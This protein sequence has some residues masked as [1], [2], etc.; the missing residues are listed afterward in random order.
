MIADSTKATPHKSSVLKLLLFFLKTNRLAL[1]A[2]KNPAA[3]SAVTHKSSNNDD[4]RDSKSTKSD[5]GEHHA[6][7]APGAD[8]PNT[9]GIVY[10]ADFFIIYLLFRCISR[11]MQQRSISV[12]YVVFYLLIRA[13][14]IALVQETASRC[15][16]PRS[17]KTMVTGKHKDTEIIRNRL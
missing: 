6:I 4:G 11:R 16:C 17:V 14:I 7:A 13:A 5:S 9:I 12:A 10:N 15:C 3:A 8:T 1:R 2:N